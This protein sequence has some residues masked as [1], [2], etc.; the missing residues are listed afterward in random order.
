MPAAIP[1]YP[2]LNYGGTVNLPNAQSCL[3]PQTG[4]PLEGLRSGSCNLLIADPQQARKRSLR[5]IQFLPK[6]THLRTI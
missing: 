6:E 1:V 5:G 2:S 4:T 3:A